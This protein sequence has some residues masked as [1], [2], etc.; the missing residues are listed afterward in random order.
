MIAPM[1]DGWHSLIS[2]ESSGAI[3]YI[4]W[5]PMWVTI[6]I[7]ILFYY[8]WMIRIP[9]WIM[10]SKL[11]EFNASEINANVPFKILIL[12]QSSFWKTGNNIDAIEQLESVLVQGN[13]VLI[14][15]QFFDT[16]NGVH[17]IHQNQGDPIN[18]GHS[19]DNAIW[20]D[21]ATIVQKA[22][23]NYVG[24][25]NKFKTQSFKTD[26]SGHPI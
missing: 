18:G 8:K 25:F 16:G 22:D 20:Q 26:D 10:P 19:T 6:R 4:R 11:K 5:K 14:L 17:D 12:E 24:F 1:A 9:P 15:G 23:G 7:P 21:G 2:N 13:K 3:D